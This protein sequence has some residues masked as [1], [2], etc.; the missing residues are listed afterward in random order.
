VFIVSILS[1]LLAIY[2]ENK[3]I[4]RK[5]VKNFLGLVERTDFS[6]NRSLIYMHLIS[7][8]SFPSSTKASFVETRVFFIEE[9]IN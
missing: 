2:K 3:D 8:V 1:A 5:E 4:N 6:L 9:I 7:T